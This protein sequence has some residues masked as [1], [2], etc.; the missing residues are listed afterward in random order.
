MDYLEKR[1][2]ELDVIR[3]FALLGIMLVNILALLHIEIPEPNT[4]DASY[5]RFLYLFV[6][7][8]F[9]AIFSFLFGVGF[10]IFL[11]KAKTKEQ[12]GTMLFLRRMA[13]LFGFG[14]IHQLFHPGEALAIYAVCGLLVLPFY[15]M[16][17]H[18]NLVIALVFLTMFALMGAKI[19]LPLPLILLGLACGQYRVFENLH[20]KR[21]IALFTAIMALLSAAALYMQYKLVPAEPFF[22]MVV[23]DE[24]GPID[25]A[26]EFLKVGITIGPILSACYIGLMLLLLQ[27]KAGHNILTPLTYYGR[28]A[29]TNYIGQTVLILLIGT[30]FNHLSY[31]DTF[32]ICVSIFVVQIAFSV[33]W[34]R[35]FKMGPLEWIW[36]IITYWRMLPLRKERK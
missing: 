1:I 27:I 25:A 17:R 21:R 19:L 7:G 13:V 22:N 30:F 32:F 8:R 31:M 35:Y 14:L 4:V 28:M 33:V 2:E 26:S 6:E 18:V 36:R 23:V 20:H 10:Y 9:Y 15:K 16:N 11:T 24:N 12:K 29:L 34:L 5:Q 3:G